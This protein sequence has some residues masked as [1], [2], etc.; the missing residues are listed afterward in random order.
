MNGTE[1]ATVASIACCAAVLIVLIATLGWYY[2]AKDERQGA[3]GR[4]NVDIVCTVKT[5][6][7]QT[8]P[9]TP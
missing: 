7:A 8:T 3:R 6:P 5:P 9:A 4:A 2:Q 1:K